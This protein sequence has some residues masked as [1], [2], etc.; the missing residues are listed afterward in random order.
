MVMKVPQTVLMGFLG[1][2]S[3][4]KRGQSFKMKSRCVDQ[5]SKMDW[6]QKL[7]QKEERHS[8]RWSHFQVRWKVKGKD[9]RDPEATKLSQMKK[10]LDSTSVHCFCLCSQHISSCCHFLWTQAVSTGSVEQ[11]MPHFSLHLTAAFPLGVT[12]M[13]VIHSVK[14]RGLY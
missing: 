2:K 9:L 5:L 13:Q 3:T 4:E 14:P 11:V 6:F 7:L 12:L 10:K 8:K 1:L